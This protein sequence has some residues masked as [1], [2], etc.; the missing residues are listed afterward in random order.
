[1]P[2]LVRFRLTGLIKN[3]FHLKEA[4]HKS[5]TSLNHSQEYINGK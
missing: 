1:M 4:V 2:T 3:P 5:V